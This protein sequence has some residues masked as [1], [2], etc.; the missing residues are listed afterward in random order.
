MSEF[1]NKPPHINKEAEKYGD[2][3]ELI[4]GIN[5]FPN[6]KKNYKEDICSH[7]GD[8]DY[9]VHKRSEF[10]REVD[11]KE[12]TNIEFEKI[13]ESDR[14][15]ILYGCIFKSENEI[16]ETKE[17]IKKELETIYLQI[18]PKPASISKNIKDMFCILTKLVDAGNDIYFYFEQFD[19]KVMK[20]ET[21][22]QILDILRKKFP[23]LVLCSFYSYNFEKENGDTQE[24]RKTI[25]EIKEMIGFNKVI[26]TQFPLRVNVKE[27][28]DISGD[29][30]E[31]N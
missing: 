15:N 9:L 1:E 18:P 24:H 29:I 25:N 19:F 11:L 20:E 13:V 28:R 17:K 26:K 16:K 23:K 30:I 8:G 7:I 6:P 3:K 27:K 12:L 4:F 21:A 31:Q 22:N 10:I 5:T 2:K 14:N